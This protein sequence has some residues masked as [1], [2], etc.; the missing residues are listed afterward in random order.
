MTEREGTYEPGGA[1]EIGAAHD[2]LQTFD[3]RD[4]LAEPAEP[5][6]E[7]EQDRPESFRGR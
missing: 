7:T 3:D 2:A 1:D 5:R 4:L 6:D